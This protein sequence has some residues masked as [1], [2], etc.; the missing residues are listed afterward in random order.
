MIIIQ[1]LSISSWSS[2]LHRI[3]LIQFTSLYKGG[4]GRATAPSL[5]SAIIYYLL[6]VVCELS[7]FLNA[8]YPP[9]TPPSSAFPTYYKIASHKDQAL[10]YFLRTLSNWW[11]QTTFGRHQNNQTTKMLEKIQEKN[12]FIQVF[13][14]H[15]QSCLDQ[16]LHI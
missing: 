13:L 2:L 4:V 3:F 6:C 1:F 11:Q 16:I 12:A 9:T 8:C 15:C 10:I 5:N 14:L 7:S